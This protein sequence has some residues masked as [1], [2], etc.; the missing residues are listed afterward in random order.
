MYSSEKNRKE[1]FEKSNGKC[2]VCGK[3]LH[4]NYE[5]FN[6]K[7]YMQIDHIIPKSLGGKDK[8]DN[9][10]AI[11]IKCN[12]SR[13]NKSGKRLK[14]I[15]INKIKRIKEIEKDFKHIE[16]DLE[17][18]LLKKEEFLEIKNY[19]EKTVEE[20]KNVFNKMV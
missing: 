11:C 20:I 15:V 3:N 1:L 19:F 14:E 5:M 17:K 9:L 2:E 6:D 8:I 7:N 12:C 10:R 4:N 18:G 16:F 13:N